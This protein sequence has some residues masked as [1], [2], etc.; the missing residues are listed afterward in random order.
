[1]APYNPSST[2]ARLAG[3]VG[4][5]QELGATPLS[6][7]ME[8]VLQWARRRKR[9]EQLHSSGHATAR[10]HGAAR[11]SVAVGLRGRSSRA[12]APPTL[13]SAESEEGR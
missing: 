2:N 10:A 5:A 3:W 11:V 13:Q 7:Q 12:N 6:T 4:L 9:G 8:G 1:M